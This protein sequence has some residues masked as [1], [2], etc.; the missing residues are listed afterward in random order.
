MRIKSLL[1]CVMLF[2]ASFT[3]AAQ[4]YNFGTDPSFVKWSQIRTPD[5]RLVY[6]RGMDSLARVYLFNLEKMRPVVNKELLLDTKPISVVLHPYTTLSNGAVSWAPKVVNLITTPEA[7]RGTMEPWYEQLASHE[8]RHVTQTQHFTKGIWRVMEYVMGEQAV[9]IGLGLFSSSVF[10]EGDAVVAETENS[11]SG[12]GRS[13]SFLMYPRAL[14]LDGVDWN[15]DKAV[16][17]SYHY[18]PINKY[19]IGYTMLAAQ[20]IKTD[21]LYFTGRF[22]HDK[23]NLYD[24]KKIFQKKSNRDYP[25]QKQ[26]INDYQEVFGE[27]WRQQLEQMGE[28]TPSTR[29]SREPRLYCDYTS[30]VPVYDTL[31]LYD[32]SIFAIKQGMEHVPEIV[33]IDTLGREH[34]VCWFSSYSSKLT[35][36][37][38]GRIYWSETV[39]HEASSLENFSEICYLDLR[40]GGYHSLVR[41]TRWFNPS[42]HPDGTVLAVTE[43]PVEGGSRLLVISSDNGEVLSDLGAPEG[44]QLLESCFSG[45]YLYVTFIGASGVGIYRKNIFADRDSRWESVAPQQRAE[46]RSLRS[47]GDGIIF[48]TDL[49]GVMN[50]YSIDASDFTLHKLTNAKFGANHPFLGPNSHLLAYSEFDRFGYHL[51][52]AGEDELEWSIAS[53]DEPAFNPI[54]EALSDQVYEAGLAEPAVDS[55][56]FDAEAYPSRKFGKLSH[57]LNIHSFAPVYYNIDRI[58][59]MSMDHYYDLASLGATVYS[60]NILGTLTTM[61]GYSY[62]GGFHAAHAKA[63]AT[64]LDFDVE[65]EVDFNDRFRTVE[66]PFEQAEDPDFVPPV[67]GSRRLVKGSVTIDYPL[68]LYHDGWLSMFIPSVT[69]DLSNDLTG[70][71]DGAGYKYCPKSELTAGFRYYKMLATPTAAIFPRHGGSLTV[72]ARFPVLGRSVYSPL[73]FMSGYLYFP[74]FVRPQGIRLSGVVQH[75]FFKEDSGMLFSNSIAE[76]PRG[77]KVTKPTRDFAKVMLDYAIP[78]WL[79]DVSI[80]G[81]LYLMRMQLIPFADVALDRSPA[82]DFK[83]YGSAGTDMMFHFHIFRIGAEIKAGLRYARLFTPDVPGKGK[84]FFGPLFGFGL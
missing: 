33:R 4:F 35:E 53:F 18:K 70:V 71:A 41:N 49:D 61:L 72:F 37:V 6:P 50:V 7:Y 59:A 3:A 10:M 81:V 40:R 75:Q 51:A 27:M 28:P 32:P 20:R 83:Y 22:F 29:L 48:A 34:H 9:G 16:F 42:V 73:A 8:L 23:A 13:A 43:Y 54:A 25:T 44:G 58:K 19:A 2:A 15:W 52:S 60:Q 79:G 63:V 84:N 21:D 46:I 62:H 56:Y 1:A 55:S 57:A 67:T 80:P 77:Y 26:F 64:L 76:L 31:S 74:G 30:P 24:V 78:I 82:G 36:A 5:F 65:A 12:R 14:L 17:G 38:G 69:A 11:E 68:N 45:D 47:T 39:M 66:F